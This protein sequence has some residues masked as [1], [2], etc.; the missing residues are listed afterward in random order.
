MLH[1]MAHPY[2]G[3]EVLHEILNLEGL[4]MIGVY[5]KIAREHIQKLR[6]EIKNQKIK[7]N[8]KNIINFRE[9]IIF[10]ND[11]DYKLIKQSPIF[12]L[13]VI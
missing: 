3:W 4:M 6:C 11:D 13:L 8:K 12:I 10:E 1:H 7:F 2:K 5:S 9:K